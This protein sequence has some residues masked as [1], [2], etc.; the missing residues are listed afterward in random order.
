MAI[1]ILGKEGEFELMC[2][3]IFSVVS[4]TESLEAEFVAATGRGDI[5]E[6][7]LGWGLSRK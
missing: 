5:A 2:P 7:L 6:C 3:E 1:E 4:K